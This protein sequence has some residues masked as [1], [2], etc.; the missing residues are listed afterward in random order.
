MG[1][2]NGLLPGLKRLTASQ[3]GM[4]LLI[5]ALLFCTTV[6]LSPSSLNINAFGSIF[7]LTIMLTMVS[8]GQTLIIISGGIDLSVGA[9]MSLTALLTVGIMN[10]QEGYFLVTLL[11]SLAVGAAVGFVN[12]VGTARIGLPPM[13]VTMC[14]SNVVTRLQ[15]VFTAGKPQGVAS[16]W[17]TKSMTY[18][19]FRVIPT[20]LFYALAVFALALFVLNR[21]R[22]GIRLF[23]TGSNERAA[24]LNGIRT[25]RTKI[26]TYML[27]GIFAGYA[28]FCG[29]GYM[30]FI[31][32]QAFDSYTM[33][34]IIAVVI[35]GALLTGGRGSH[36]GTLAGALLITVLTNCLS[37][38]NMSQSATDMVMG[39]VLIVLLAVYNRS[40]PVRQ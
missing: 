6:A 34:S 36:T 5:S 23:L 10:A 13:I 35:G 8:L 22:Y 19:I 24:R 1:N 2:V 39:M 32:C 26:L 11:L 40:A 21:S 38:L 14:V 17:F 30:N 29:A 27:A 3:T 16:P 20:S 7:A 33:K 28:G 15:Y 9:V 31:R 18:R 12:G 4:A 37:V 25:V